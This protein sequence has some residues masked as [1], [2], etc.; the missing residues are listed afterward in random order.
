MSS[1]RLLL[2]ILMITTA[3]GCGS[4]AGPG[5]LHG[6]QGEEAAA[7]SLAFEA[8]T[9]DGKQFSGASL[10]GKPAVLWFWAP[11]CPICQREAAEMAT[12]AHGHPEVTFVGVAAQDQ[13]PAMQD[14]VSRYQLGFF[15]HLADVDAAVWRRFNVTQQPAF[16]FV[17]RHGTVTVVTSALSEPAIASRVDALMAS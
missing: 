16:A 5:P 8:K 4:N 13:V 10:R 14:F 7:Q 11:W 3:A 6:A 17:D 2:A 12:V 15:T 9:I 1:A